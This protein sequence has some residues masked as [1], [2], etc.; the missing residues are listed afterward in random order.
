MSKIKRT[1]LGGLEIPKELV[2]KINSQ[3]KLYKQTR[4]LYDWVLSLPQEKQDLV[5]NG[6]S[7]S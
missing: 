6:K 4:L 1:Y 2:N 5:F 7:K 3:D